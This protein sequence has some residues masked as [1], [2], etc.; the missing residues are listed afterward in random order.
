MGSAAVLTS[1][2]PIAGGYLTQ[3]TWRAIFWINLPFAVVAIVLTLMAG[4]QQQRRRESIDYAGALLI[5]L[6]MGLSVFGFE[7]ATTWGWS[8]V[9]TWACIVGGL[10]VLLVFAR[11]ET[12][13]ATPLIKVQI[14]RDRAFLVDNG[15]LFF[16]MIAFVPV[17]FFASVYSQISLG[18]GASNAGLYL[19]VFFAGFA[20][21]AQIGGRWLD[22]GG[23]RRPLIVG[24]VLSCVGFALWASKVTDLKLGAQWIYVAMAGAG[25]GLILGPSST[26]A[27]NRSIGASYGEVTGIT[28]TVRNY[29]STL[30]IAVL[31]SVLGTVF[32][33]RLS[34]SFEKL[35]IPTSVARQIASDVSSASGSRDMGSAPAAIREQISNAIAHDYAVGTSYVL[36]GMAIALGVC[37]FIALR[38]PGDKVEERITADSVDPQVQDAQAAPRTAGRAEPL[39]GH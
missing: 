18:Y 9:G 21:A 28:Q 17:F 16:S 14:F 30:G 31:G 5:A 32:S 23:A 4:I 11:F 19:L 25:I 37:F 38:H 3:W 10:L 6:G 13:V 15:V 20:P 33:N 2:G 36:Y 34:T 24:S 26:D 12:R 35:D 8:N 22:E 39:A 1:V 27:V 29:A 7:Q